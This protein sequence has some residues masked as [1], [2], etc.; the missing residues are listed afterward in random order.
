M[1][2]INPVTTDTHFNHLFLMKKEQNI[3]TMRVNSMVFAK[4]SYQL[5]GSPK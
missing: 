3:D 2:V 5:R 4:K 1:K